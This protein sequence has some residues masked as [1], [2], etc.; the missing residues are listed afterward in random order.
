M[1]VLAVE[2]L[3]L[4]LVLGSATEFI[5]GTAATHNVTKLVNKKYL[6]FIMIFKKLLRTRKSFCES[7]R[8]R[9]ADPSRIKPALFFPFVVVL[10]SGAH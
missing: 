9:Q 6:G 5:A 3:D 7:L 2:V 10:I 8:E 1:V 4:D